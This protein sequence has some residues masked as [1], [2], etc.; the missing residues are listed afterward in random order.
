MFV[1][2]ICFFLLFF[3]NITAHADNQSSVS[4]LLIDAN[5]NKI[6]YNQDANEL[7]YPA[8]LTKMMTVYVMFDL[9]NKGKLSFDHKIKISLKAA[10][11]AA[12]S[13]SL[14]LESGSEITVLNAI[15]SLIIYSANDVA[16]AVAESIAG[17]EERF[18]QYMNKKAQDLGMI[19]T[20]FYNASGLPHKYQLTTAHDMARLAIALYHNFPDYYV[21]FSETSFRLN[22]RVITGH[23]N[24]TA[25]YPGANGVKTGW[26]EKSK[27]NLVSSAERNRDQL[28]GVVM[29]ADSAEARDAIMA[30]L[31]DTGFSKLSGNNLIN[32]FSTFHKTSRKFKSDSNVFDVVKGKK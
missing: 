31:L 19:N 4:A 6:L 30:K 32:K 11:Q 14:G 10:E 1:K 15:R 23:N 9:L 12:D 2:I 28:I 5:S 20:K 25:N 22:G 18:A 7:R 29:G 3:I 21:F 24:I 8:S 13:K 16:V 26:T 27:F 17:N